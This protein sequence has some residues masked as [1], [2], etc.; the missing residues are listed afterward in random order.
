MSTSAPN[1][2]RT[3]Q[4]PVSEREKSHS[5]SDAAFSGF[6]KERVASARARIA[7]GGRLV[8]LDEARAYLLRIR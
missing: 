3:S 5:K 2:D 7:A 8:E 4:P 6:S 1:S